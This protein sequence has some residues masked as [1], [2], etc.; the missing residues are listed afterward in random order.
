MKKHTHTPS[1]L[2]PQQTKTTQTQLLVPMC[3][4]ENKQD[5]DLVWTNRGAG[6][7]GGVTQLQLHWARSSQLCLCLSST[8]LVTHTHFLG[9]GEHPASLKSQEP[10]F[11]SVPRQQPPTHWWLRQANKHKMA[12]VIA[13]CKKIVAA[14]YCDTYK[15]MLHETES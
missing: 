12:G 15:N 4:W 2:L 1:S 9:W 7:Q 6:E 10:H 3:T 14:Q 8:L 11:F 13:R 5:C